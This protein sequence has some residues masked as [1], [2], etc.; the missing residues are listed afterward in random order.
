[1]RFNFLST[2]KIG[3]LGLFFC[4]FAQA[5]ELNCTVRILS[6]GLQVTD[7]AIFQTL[8]TDLQTFM[9]NTKWTN[10]AYQ[11][12]E[13]I[14]CTFN[15]NIR[16]E[17]GSNTF[18]AEASIQA[19]RPVY[20]SS[21]VTPTFE[22]KD[23]EWNFDYIQ[24]MPLQFDKNAYLT[25]LTSLMAYYAY[26]ILGYDADSFVKEGGTPYFQMAQSVMN[27]AQTSGREGWMGTDSRRRSRYWIVDNMLNT[28]FQLLRQA[29]YSYHIQG[30]DKMYENAE[31]GRQGVVEAI[32]LVERAA[33]EN[34]NSI[35][36]DVFSN[37]K[38]DEIIDV[39]KDVSV[40][41]AQIVKVG[42]MLASVSPGTSQEFTEQT[43]KARNSRPTS[44]VRPNSTMPTDRDSRRGQ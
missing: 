4:T 10:D 36:L 11:P 5:Q 26:I 16:E 8:E 23:V 25:E 9:N 3:I 34:P 2:I 40:P 13:R 21:Y 15:I 20:N 7:P 38:G 39:F 43:S 19:N 30:L 12:D 41:P 29:Y 31:I 24:Y 32:T 22:H 33:K 17:A 44:G 18:K 42:N 1:M 28:R 6:T 27:K 37:T 14:E 35:A